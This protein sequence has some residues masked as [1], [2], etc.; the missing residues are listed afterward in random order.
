MADGRAQRHERAFKI[1]ALERMAAGENVSA[2]SREL[3]GNRGTRTYLRGEGRSPKLL[4]KGVW[5]LFPLFRLPTNPP[6]DLATALFLPVERCAT[7]GARTLSPAG[8]SG[9][10]Q[11]AGA[12]SVCHLRSR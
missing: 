5:S 7:A 8:S 9:P 3:V 1:A 11:S 6:V 2:L 10:A 12:W 4:W